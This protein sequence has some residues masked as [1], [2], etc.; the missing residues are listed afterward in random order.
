MSAPFRAVR[1]VACVAALSFLTTLVGC[2]DSNDGVKQDST[3]AASTGKP[4]GKA[5]PTDVAQPMMSSDTQRTMLLLE[6]QPPAPGPQRPA[7]PPPDRRSGPAGVA[8]Q[9]RGSVG[10]R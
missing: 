10:R 4:S 5:G 8:D 7:M 3:P 1:T 6:D 9:P 2:G